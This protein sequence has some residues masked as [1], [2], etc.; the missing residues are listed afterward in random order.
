MMR[1]IIPYKHELVKK[2]RELR[3]N[4]TLSERMLWKYLKRKQLRGYDFDRQKPIDNYIVDFFCYD[5]MLAIEIDGETHLNK[6]EYDEHREQRLNEL[7]IKI[8]RFDGHTVLKN[9]LG[10][11]QTIVDWI[12]GYEKHTPN[13]SQEGK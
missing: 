12:E 2:D 11:V 3:N 8:L 6:K 13:P 4:A 10:V 7:G 1:K 5:L 9:T